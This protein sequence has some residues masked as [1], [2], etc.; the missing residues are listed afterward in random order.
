MADVGGH[1]DPMETRHRPLLNPFEVGSRSFE[2]LQKDL[3]ALSRA[4]LLDIIHAFDLN[5]ANEDIGWMSDAQLRHFI[6]VAVETQLLHR[7]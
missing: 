1:I 6:C 2:I 7:R 4:R 3:G 5:P